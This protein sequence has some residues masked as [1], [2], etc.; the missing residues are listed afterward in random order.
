VTKPIEHW[1]S[2]DLSSALGSTSVHRLE[3]DTLT[4]VS[5]VSLNDEYKHSEKLVPMLSN[6][7]SDIRIDVADID[8]FVTNRGPGSFTGLRV[9]FA[10][11]KALAMAHGKPIDTVSGS[12]ARALAWTSAEK[13]SLPYDDVFVLTHV[14]L[15]R[16]V[17][18]R[19]QVRGGNQLRMVSEVLTEGFFR[20]PDVEAGL[21]LIDG[22]VPRDLLPQSEEIKIVEFPIT[23]RYL[24]ES[25]PKAAT[26]QTF[27]S[28]QEWVALSPVYFGDKQS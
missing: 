21:V 9:A 12:E 23:A 15:N 6:M 4:L 17:N 22:K 16:Y 24:A 3:N 2:I 14:S 25:L 20:E 18:A 19:F 10:T 26:R 11:I 7:L 27:S 5:S 13:S 28:V 1:L 8:R